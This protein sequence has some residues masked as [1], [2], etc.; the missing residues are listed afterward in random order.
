MAGRIATKTT[1]VIGS[2]ALALMIPVYL[3]RRTSPSTLCL[4]TLRFNS[5]SEKIEAALDFTKSKGLLSSGDIDPA[6]CCLFDRGGKDIPPIQ[7]WDRMAGTV[8]YVHIPAEF[9]LNRKVV[10]SNSGYS[11]LIVQMNNCGGVEGL[12]SVA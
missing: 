7:I 9:V 5:D 8:G 11:E 3:A 2:V 10:S 1:L 12:G 4:E 6:E